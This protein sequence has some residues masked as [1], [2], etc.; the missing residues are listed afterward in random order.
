MADA[1]FLRS[2]VPQPEATV[3]FGPLSDHQQCNGTSSASQQHAPQQPRQQQ[4]LPLLAP[5]PRY[6]TEVF[7]LLGDSEDSIK[8]RQ[9]EFKQQRQKLDVHAYLEDCW[10]K[11]GFHTAEADRLDEAMQRRHCD[12]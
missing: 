5:Q 7:E 10:A 1:H 4:P 6:D 11:T 9:R 3:H 2:C 12:L 8:E